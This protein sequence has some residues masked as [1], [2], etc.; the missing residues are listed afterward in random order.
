MFDPIKNFI[1]DVNK[2]GFRHELE[3]RSFARS[4][5]E[6]R[7]FKD[8]IALSRRLQQAKKAEKMRDHFA[9]T[10]ACFAPRNGG[11]KIF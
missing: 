4:R 1:R 6:L 10:V 7:R 8:R 9:K 2:S 5:S 3:K 11:S